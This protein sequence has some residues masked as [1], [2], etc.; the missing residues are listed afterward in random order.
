VLQ[1]DGAQRYLPVGEIRPGMTILLA[2]GDRVPVDARVVEGQSELDSSLASGESLPRP[3]APG[4]LLQA[5]TLN[6]TGPLTIEAVAAAQDSFLAEMTRMMEATEAGRPAYRRIADHAARLYA[7]VIHVTAFATFAGWMLATGDVRLSATT[8]IAVLIITCPCALGLAVP[9]VQAMAARR[10]F[11]QRIMVKDGGA[12]ER[13]AEIDHAIFDKTGTLTSGAP[14]LI[15]GGTVDPALLAIAAALAARSRHPYSLAIAQEGRDRAVPPVALADLREHPGV[16]IEGRMGAKL[17]RLGRPPAA[18]EG[19]AT[20]VT[21]S[22][23]GHSLCSFDFHDIE[24]PGAPQAIAAVTA[25]GIPVEILSGDHEEP[26]RRMASLLGVPY[27][28]GVS[29]AGKV[30]HINA[31]AANGRKVLMVGDG[32]NDTPALAAAHVS[33]AT[34][35]AADIGRNAADIVFLREDL[36]A[37]DEAIEVARRARTL[38]RQNLL[39]AVAY[40][41]MAVPVAILGHVTPLVAAIAMSASSIAVMCNALRLGRRPAGA[42]P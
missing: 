40:N 26:V 4:S 27:R 15:D 34:S 7:P 10:L 42:R 33:I 1:S 12:L 35:S 6:L 5:G 25:R 2:A 13:L 14:K 20:G 23:D 31:L 16:G 11:G 28:A 17:Y 39:L 9:M 24:R 18:L 21:L 36:G 30:A 8:A 38:V 22:A 32:L 37:V 19:D 29:P 3:V 41:A